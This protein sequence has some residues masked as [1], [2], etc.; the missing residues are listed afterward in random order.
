MN[1]LSYGHGLVGPESAAQGYFA[2]VPARDLSWARAAFLAVLPRAPS[3]LDPYAHLDRVVLRQRALLQALA[4]EGVIDA[5]SLGRALDEP[6]VVRPL[7]RP[8]LVSHFVEVVRGEITN[9]GAA[10][11]A[12]VTTLDLDCSATPKGSCAPTSR[13]SRTA[14][15][16]TRR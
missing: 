9:T 15:R 4:G 5:A 12:I 7:A 6:I 10:Q 14:A 3:F 13:R 1:R 8:F 11:Q 16:A 2:G